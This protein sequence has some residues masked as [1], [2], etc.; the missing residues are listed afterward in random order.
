VKYLNGEKLDKTYPIS[1]PAITK[2]NADK[3]TGQ[4]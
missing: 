4:F 3:F 1:C 2:E